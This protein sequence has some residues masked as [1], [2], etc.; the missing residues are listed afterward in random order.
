M[1]GAF[2]QPALPGYSPW[3]TARQTTPFLQ[4]PGAQGPQEGV[5]AGQGLAFSPQ[6]EF[7]SGGTE[8][9][10]PPS[11]V[12]PQP[13]MWQKFGGSGGASSSLVQPQMG[14]PNGAGMTPPPIASPPP[15]QLSMPSFGAGGGG[16]TP[17]MNMTGQGAPMPGGFGRVPQLAAALRGPNV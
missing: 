3:P 1:A 2:E 9:S 13:D 11:S 15:T 4:V 14:S 6:A 12:P 8:G 10:A 17:N 7:F 16:G 5:A